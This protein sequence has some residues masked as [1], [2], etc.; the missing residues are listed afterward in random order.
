MVCCLTLAGCSSFG[1]SKANPKNWFSSNDQKK[2]GA[3]NGRTPSYEDQ[4]H[5]SAPGAGSGILAGR[6][7][8]SFNQRRGGASIQVVSVDEGSGAAAV[9][10]TA[11]NDGYFVI[12]KLEPGQRYR[13]IARWQQDGQNLAG[14]TLATPPNPVVV[15]KMSDDLVGHDAPPFRPKGTDGSKQSDRQPGATPGRPEADGSWSPEAAPKYLH[16]LDRGSPPVRPRDIPA[17]PE[18]QTQIGGNIPPRANIPNGASRDGL[19]IGEPAA[20]GVSGA[21]SPMCVLEGKRLTD[22]VLPDLA[23]QPFQLSQHRSKLVLLDFWGTWCAPCIQSMPYLADLQRRHAPQGLEVIGIAYEEEM[24]FTRKAEQV[25]FI[26]LRQ[27]VNY[28]ILVGT[29]DSCPVLTK[30]DV[31]SFPTLILVDENGEIVWRGEGTSPQNKA[32]LELEINR[33]LGSR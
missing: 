25:N 12:E 15:I 14:S 16:E 20:R 22:F 2:S 28:K 3:G 29:G 5:A 7:I 21:T 1:D 31:R 19:S 30:L 13:L 10:A 24:P 32:R 17:R 27:G 9:E 8:D 11:N 6:V 18:L 4:G 23:G 33:R 26:R